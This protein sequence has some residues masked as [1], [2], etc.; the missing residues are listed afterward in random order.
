MKTSRHSFQTDQPLKYIA[1][2]SCITAVC[3]VFFFGLSVFAGACFGIEFL[4]SPFGERPAIA[5]ST[6]LS[7][8]L[9]AVTLLA[10]SV[11][12]RGHRR[13]RNL[14]SVFA[15]W[16]LLILALCV[17]PQGL[18]PQ[19][20]E[21]DQPPHVAASI[22][23]FAMAPNTAV[24]VALMAVA[25]LFHD[26][27][28]PKWFMRIELSSTLALVV[29]LA[30]GVIVV[31][32]L[33][34]EP[35]LFDVNQFQPMSLSA[36]ASLWILST[37]MLML[38]RTD[39]SSNLFFSSGTGGMLWRQLVPYLTLL[40]IA[41]GYLCLIT[42]KLRLF[43]ITLSVSVFVIAT[44]LT[45]LAVSWRTAMALDN[46]S[47]RRN[48]DLS[49]LR[50]SQAEIEHLNAQ[51][52]A[53][54]DEALESARMKPEF[55]ADMRR[56]SIV[57][58]EDSQLTRLAIRTIL[59]S[60]PQFQVV[61]EAADAEN[62]LLLIA[63]QAPQ[64]VLV[65]IGL[66]GMNGIEATKCIKRD[67]PTTRVVMLTS[68]DG[69]V[70]VFHSFD[71]GADGYVIK[72]AFTDRIELAIKSVSKGN[73]WLDPA[74][75][76]RVLQLASTKFRTPGNALNR[77]VEPAPLSA[78]EKSVLSEVAAQEPSC[79]DGMCSVD[80]AFLRKLR[81]FAGSSTDS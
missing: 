50:A 12:L 62:G 77:S 54:R 43:D 56:L 11:R 29:S 46:V 45:L 36:A 25:F 37:C 47:A 80:P 14:I 74:I 63:Q 70:D 81:R 39:A 15:P 22:A 42:I 58:I 64:V 68:H 26:F 16:V 48:A 66:P 5:A 23:P 51:L 61:G 73:T 79:H 72:D 33:Y 44:V 35:I 4:Q 76:S 18:R 30:T 71:A 2:Q 8:V 20:V 49:A 13:W 1:T 57:L 9:A 34:S 59:E 27:R 32:H 19:T 65:D 38:R 69:D 67:H 40:P 7:L 55:L 17:L 24:L 31:G 6:G 21:L 3:C 53:A 52:V 41:L 60:V 75:A 78:Q 10:R 28:S